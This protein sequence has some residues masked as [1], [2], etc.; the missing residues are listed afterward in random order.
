ML[1]R[2]WARS[3]TLNSGWSL[4]WRWHISSGPRR[5]KKF[6]PKATSWRPASAIVTQPRRK[7][8]MLKN[9]C[10]CLKGDCRRRK[11][12]IGSPSCVR[13]LNPGGCVEFLRI[14]ATCTLVLQ[15]TNVTTPSQYRNVTP[16]AVVA[17]RPPRTSLAP[18]SHEPR[19]PPL[20]PGLL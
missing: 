20:C 16:A 19:A 4:W 2:R 15:P 3:S 5:R 9:E 6:R 7:T 12:L 13:F 10:S 1:C 11:R 18:P 8:A 17:R 14:S